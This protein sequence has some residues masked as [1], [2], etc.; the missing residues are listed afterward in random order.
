M[1]GIRGS[2]RISGPDP[3]NNTFGE[4]LADRLV[5]YCSN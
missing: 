1:L 5:S 4:E 3:T 2:G